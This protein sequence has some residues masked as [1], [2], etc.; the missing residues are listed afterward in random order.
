[1]PAAHDIL[2]APRPH[3]LAPA[4]RLLPANTHL[5]NKHKPPPSL[6]KYSALVR[7]VDRKELAE[8]F[9]PDAVPD[10]FKS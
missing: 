5:E 2:A 9:A 7:F 8:Y 3:T 4:N 1:M 6:R 10:E